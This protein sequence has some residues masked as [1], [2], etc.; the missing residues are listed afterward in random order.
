MGTEASGNGPAF[1]ARYSSHILRPVG[2]SARTSVTTPLILPDG[3]FTLIA[4]VRGLSSRVPKHVEIRVLIDPDVECKT[5][6][7]ILRS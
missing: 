3:W 6:A 1:A 4:S 5:A 7:P 2:E